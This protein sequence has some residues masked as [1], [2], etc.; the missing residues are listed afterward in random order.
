MHFGNTVRFSVQRIDQ[1]PD[2]R[3]IAGPQ[4]SRKS[5][6]TNQ[7]PA[8]PAVP[9][10]EVVRRCKRIPISAD[11]SAHSAGSTPARILIVDDER[12]NREIL[13][14]LLRRSGY[15]TTAVESGEAAIRLT[16]EQTFD[17]VMFDL[18]MPGMDGFECL[19]TIRERFSPTELPVV[20]VTA[21]SERDRIVSAFRINANDYV[22]KPIDRDIT[23][24]RIAAH[25]RFRSMTQALRESE[26]RYALAARGSNDGLWD[27][28]LLLDEVY[29]SDRW[30]AMPGIEENGLERTPATWISRIHP[31][32][33]SGFLQTMCGRVSSGV[34]HLERE[35]RMLHRDGACRWMLC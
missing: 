15:S 33:V 29:Y 17:A 13:S 2:P 5:S 20:I 25:A 35:L 32:D 14:S 3:F 23:L 18:V 7:T 6:E 30:K 1:H 31:E 22:T 21:E 9:A 10:P 19:R 8:S 11:I 4:P 34:T 28:N 16:N 27:W 12:T 24:A 26:E